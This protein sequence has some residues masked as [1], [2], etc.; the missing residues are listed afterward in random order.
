MKAIKATVIKPYPNADY[1]NGG[2]SS[3]YNTVY[4]LDEEG[5]TEIKGDEANVVKIKIERY[6]KDYINLY[7]EPIAKVDDTKTTGYMASGCTLLSND[8]AIQKYEDMI[9]GNVRLHDRV[10]SWEMYEALSH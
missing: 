6:G 10:E 9:Q 3:I 8:R 7:A 4:I 5:Q 2:I 1:S